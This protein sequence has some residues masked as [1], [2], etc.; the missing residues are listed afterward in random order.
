MQ[1]V[2]PPEARTPGQMPMLAQALTSVKD[3]ENQHQISNIVYESDASKGS[4]IRGRPAESDLHPLQFSEHLGL[5]D[6]E[7]GSPSPVRR[8]QWGGLSAAWI[9]GTVIPSGAHHLSCQHS[10]GDPSPCE[11]LTGR[12][13]HLTSG[14]LVSGGHDGF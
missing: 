9:R 12:R 7:G 14:V 11:A 3:A 4:R 8:R 5:P 6:F 2:Y 1:C 10:F 13:D